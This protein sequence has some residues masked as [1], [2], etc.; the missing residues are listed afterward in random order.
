MLDWRRARHRYSV[1]NASIGSMRE[2]R[3][4][5]AYAAANATAQRRKITPEKTAG[6]VE[7]CP[8]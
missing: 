3:R 2:A 6:F 7:R 8:K 5:G 1:R 4:A